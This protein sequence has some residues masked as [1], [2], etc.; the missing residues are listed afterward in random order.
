MRKQGGISMKRGI[1]FDLDGTLWDSSLQVVEAF[2]KVLR[3]QSDVKRL[4]TIQDMQGVMGKLLSE[5]AM[6]FFGYLG[7]E[8]AMELME[9]CAEEE[10]AYLDENGGTLYPHLEEVLKELKE[11]GYEL[12]IVSNCQKGYIEGFFAYHKL[13]KYFKDYEN[14][15]RTG[16][17]K[18]D[19]IKLVIE[20]NHLEQA[21]YIGD[22]RGD[23]EAAKLAGIPFVHAAYGFGQVEE[24]AYKISALSE[25]V[26]TADR[27]MN[28]I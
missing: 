19:N 24:A 20:R 17:C 22:T 25:V 5:I 3:E 6:I 28:A 18:G 21:I 16:L 10:Q 15:G 23:F 27:I 9:M 4:I 26:E 11:K 12:F 8:R 13:D 14:P 7:N 2:N 1:I